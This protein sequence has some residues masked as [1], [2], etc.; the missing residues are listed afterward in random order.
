MLPKV[1]IWGAGGHALVVADI[2]RVR[3]EYVIVG[4][5]YDGTPG[6]R[7]ER[8]NGFEV[9]GGRERLDDLKSQGA[10]H[11]IFGFGDCTARLQL[12]SSV[13]AMG[14]EWATAVHPRATVAVD[15]LIGLGTVVAAGAVVNP[16]ARVGR[17]CIIN[18]GATVDHECILGDAVHVGPGAHL[19]GRCVVGDAAWIG[20][21]AI[22]LDRIRIGAGSMIGAGAVITR[23]VPEKVV[24]YGVPGRVVRSVEDQAKRNRS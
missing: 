8:V 17:H 10:T 22:V 19:G 16:G 4:L 13:E 1:V 18:T 15:A 3:A 6:R 14:L 7:G 11:V 2:L 9:L 23:D 5:L 12:A 21:G 24:V 20:I